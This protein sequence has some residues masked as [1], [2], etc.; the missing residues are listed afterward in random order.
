M[1]TSYLFSIQAGDSVVKK[2]YGPDTQIEFLIAERDKLM[3]F[4]HI[5][6]IK[7]TQIESEN[8]GMIRGDQ[9][10]SE[11]VLGV[12]GSFLEEDMKTA[13]DSSVLIPKVGSTWIWERGKPHAEE[14][15]VVTKVE[16]F[17]NGVEY[18]V[19][20]ARI[21]E[22]PFSSGSDVVVNDLS[23]FWEAV[24]PYNPESDT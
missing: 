3:D 4:S 17:D 21:D 15:I 20:T 19:W 7:I 1:H 23:R 14:Y 6:G 5:T 10:Q 24:T 22:K 8:L 11:V 12:V 16:W 2:I 13:I 18:N 9:I